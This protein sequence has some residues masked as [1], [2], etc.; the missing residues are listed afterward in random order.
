MAVCRAVVTLNKTNGIAED[1]VQ[2]VWHFSDD[3]V[4]TGSMPSGTMDDIAANLAA[5]YVA[6]DE[7]FSDSVSEVANAHTITV[8]R[9]FPGSPGEGDD[10]LDSPSTVTTFTT[11]ATSVQAPLPSEVA[12]CL[13]MASF[14]SGLPEV[15]G[16]TRPRAR[17]RG[18]VY[19]GPF[20]VDG[21]DSA[22]GEARPGATLRTFIL[23]AA[24]AMYDAM[25]ADDATPVVYSRTAGAV[26]QVETYSI[27]NA[28]DTVR[29]RGPAPTVR[30]TRTVSP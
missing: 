8:A 30:T 9:L 4:A 25:L 6:L 7:K 17:R 23:D 12:I 1:G 13:S 19:L 29:S 26:Y 18:R 5:F 10:T 28:Y 15:S 14:L 11:P 24:E 21:I 3:L 16:S 22:D 2:N 27:D 20:S